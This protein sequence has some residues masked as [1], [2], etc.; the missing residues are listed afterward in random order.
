METRSA[1][2]WTGKTRG[3]GAGRFAE[4]SAAV[5]DAAASI[6]DSV[7]SGARRVSIEIGGGTGAARSAGG[8]TE[9]AGASFLASGGLGRRGPV[10]FPLGLGGFKRERRSSAERMKRSTLSSARGK[11]ARP[12]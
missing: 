2:R 1:L 8:G 7:F 4:I 10:P 5:A 6:A 12:G 9:A 11:L 3:E